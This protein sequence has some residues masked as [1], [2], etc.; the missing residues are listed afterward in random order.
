MSDNI[1]SIDKHLLD[2][3]IKPFSNIWFILFI[4]ISATVAG[5]YIGL[6]KSDWSWIN[7]FGAINI[8][9]GLLLTMSPMFKKGIYLSQSGAGMF[10]SL[11]PQGRTVTTTDKERKIGNAVAL[12]VLIAF[13]GTIQ[14]AFG[15]I[16]FSL[17]L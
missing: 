16:L 12:G 9:S 15:D 3:L 13:F 5:I 14:N 17:I 2:P 6:I 10:A 11:D 4:A 7:R 8:V 1:S